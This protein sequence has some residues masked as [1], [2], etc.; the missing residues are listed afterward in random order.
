MR[1]RG[2]TGVWE[3]FMPGLGDGEAYKYELIGAHG[4]VLPQKAD[5]FGF[6]SEHPP[7]TASV[8]RKLDGHTWGDGAWMRKREALHRI[9]QPISI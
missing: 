9:D 5:P 1:G 8:V 4:E 3:I 7:K 6:G 2:N